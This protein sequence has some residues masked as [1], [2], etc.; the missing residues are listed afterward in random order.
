LCDVSGGYDSTTVF[1][2]AKLLEQRHGGTPAIVPWAFR[3]SQ[4]N[5]GQFQDIVSRH[6]NTP[7]HVIERL[8]CLP[9]QF[10]DRGSELPAGGFV[11]GGA[12]AQSVRQLAESQGI[13]SRLTGLAADVL[14][15]KGGAP[16]HLAEWLRAGRVRD[17]ARHVRGYMR[18]GSHSL[19]HLLGE[20]TFGSVDLLAGTFRVDPPDWVLPSFLEKI[21]ASQAEYG[22][23]PRMLKSSAREYVYRHTVFQLPYHE[24][25]L[26]DQRFPLVS[27]P[28]VEFVLGLDWKYL[29][30]PAESRV[31][32]SRAL[33][34]ILPEPVRAGGT[35]A[36]HNAAVLEGLRI[37]W[38]RIQHL[39]TGERL[40]DLGVVNRRLFR[41]A[42]EKMRS[43][44]VG[45]NRA[46]SL[47][48][49][50]LEAWLATKY[51]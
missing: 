40:A 11:Q 24:R 51:E 23:L 2:I 4:G 18:T 33:K 7:I 27:L 10:L 19:W 39:L 21:R 12:L 31:L 50:Y 22:Q 29:V 45:T 8:T 9:F 35:V 14:F 17:W 16:L 37:F 32:L 47:T 15:Q 48:A 41:R 13:R 20:C 49:L 25:M 34:G 46:Y 1:S 6:F 28:L 30:A 3:N 26:P 5:E 44:N 36:H 38:P 42:I 43:G